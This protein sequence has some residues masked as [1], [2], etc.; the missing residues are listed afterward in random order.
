MGSQS[1]TSWLWRLYRT[2]EALLTIYSIDAPGITPKPHTVNIA[3]NIP[4]SPVRKGRLSEYRNIAILMNLFSFKKDKLLMCFMH[5]K[6]IT[7]DA[8][9]VTQIARKSLSKNDNASSKTSGATTNVRP[10]WI[11]STIPTTLTNLMGEIISL[12]QATRFS[13]TSGS[14]YHKSL[15]F[16]FY[17][18]SSFFLFRRAFRY[19]TRDLIDSLSAAISG[20][21]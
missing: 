3:K 14:R 4:M 12:R 1:Q 19:S 11:A 10:P 9:I 13:I 16:E 17:Y 15:R 2:D 18:S 21:F 8:A 20:I 5:T 6:K 7:G